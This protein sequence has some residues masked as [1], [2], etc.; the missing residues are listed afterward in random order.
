MA[1]GAPSP[2]DMERVHAQLLLLA[3]LAEEI[4]PELVHLTPLL[5][6]RSSRKL[7]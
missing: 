1:T 5:G 4:L 2:R 6:A 3:H 7:T